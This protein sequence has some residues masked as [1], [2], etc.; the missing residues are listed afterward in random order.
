[1]QRVILLSVT[2]QFSVRTQL[3]SPFVRRLKV[4]DSCHT[5]RCLPATSPITQHRCGSGAGLGPNQDPQYLHTKKNFPTVV[6]SSENECNTV[7]IAKELMKRIGT[8]FPG[9]DNVLE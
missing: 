8:T 2:R 5:V 6:I 1:M 4:K 9:Y 7:P 3:E